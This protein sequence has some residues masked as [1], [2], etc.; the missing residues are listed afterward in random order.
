MNSGTAIQTKEQ[1][2]K[3]LDQQFEDRGTVVLDSELE[4]GGNMLPPVNN[5]TDNK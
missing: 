4:M 3:A 1:I 5:D 2:E